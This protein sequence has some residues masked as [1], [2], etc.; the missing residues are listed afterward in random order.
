MRDSLPRGTWVVLSKP[1][2]MFPPRGRTRTG[3]AVGAIGVIKAFDSGVPD[4]P[5]DP[6]AYLVQFLPPWA[7]HLMLIQAQN[8]AAYRPQTMGQMEWWLGA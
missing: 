2:R 1:E 8:L 7:S 6:D 3:P 4:D 5:K